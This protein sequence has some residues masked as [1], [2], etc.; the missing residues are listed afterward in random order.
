MI[1]GPDLPGDEGDGAE[2]DDLCVPEYHLSDD[3]VASMDVAYS[4]RAKEDWVIS[5]PLGSLGG[6]PGRRFHTI[7]LAEKWVREKYG[8]R[9][10]YRITEA[11]TNSGN[12]W[13]WLIRGEKHDVQS[14]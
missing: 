2:P 5:G 1:R 4:T 7:K 12:R 10:K 9:V 13:A 8:D 14:G 11:T 6:G 3:E